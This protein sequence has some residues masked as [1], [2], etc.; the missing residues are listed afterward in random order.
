MNPLFPNAVC[1]AIVNCPFVLF[2]LFTTESCL[3]LC[4]PRNYSTPGFPVLHYFPEFA[5]THV[6]W[7][8]DA[9]Q[10]SHPL[11]P[12]FPSAL[13][14]P[15]HQGLFQWVSS[16]HQEVLSI[17]ASASASAS[18][19]PMNIQGWLPSG[20]TGFISLQSKGLSRAFSSTTV[21]NYQFF[22]ISLLYR[23]TLTSI[24]DD[25]KNHSFDSMDIC[26]QKWCLCFL[27]WSLGM[28]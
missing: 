14:L 5:Q 7:V 20:L 25:W 12:P 16:L 22:G 17:R 26:W 8:S 15:L 13:D 24:H 1:C 28:S 3:I 2:F 23:T 18:S 10:P 6:H 9:I 4:N 19:L 27:I 21:R 11:L